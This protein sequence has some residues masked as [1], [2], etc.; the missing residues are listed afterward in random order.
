MADGIE[1]QALMAALAGGE[2]QA[3]ARLIALFGPGVQRYA[4]QVLRNRADAEDV[5]Q[6]VFLRVWAQ[7]ARY[8]PSRGAVSTWIWRIALRLCIDRNRRSALRRFLGLEA[9]PEPE[10]EA[11]GVDQLLDGRRRLAVARAALGDLPE[12]QRQAILMR[13]AGGLASAEI[14]AAMGISEGA[15]EQLLVRARATLR[16]TF[17]TRG[18]Q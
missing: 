11:P 9:A 16:A 15:V 18:M 3:L 1:A 8:D 13:S 7:A 10:D 5:A 14:A 4:A 17:E 12:R 2:R 6:E